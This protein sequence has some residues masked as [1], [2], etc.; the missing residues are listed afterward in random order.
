MDTRIPKIA[1]Q[2]RGMVIEN[3][4]I[5]GGAGVN[6][7]TKTNCEKF[8]WQDWLLVPFLVRM[9][10]Q[11]R[12]RPLGILRNIFLDIGGISFSMAFV[13]LSMEDTLEEY[14]IILGRP[15]LRQAKVRHD[16]A[17]NQLTIR[18]GRRKVKIPLKEKARLNNAVWP[19]IAETVNMTE[20]LDEDEEE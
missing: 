6:I 12:V 17:A 18:R 20:G 2:Y 5:D 13:V 14:N 7:V 15:W 1:I 4:L 9:A 10:D 3:V 19:A 16:W 11:W 8:G